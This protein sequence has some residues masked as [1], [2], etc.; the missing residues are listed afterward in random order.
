MQA[1]IDTRSS[2]D[3]MCPA[4][5]SIASLQSDRAACLMSSS[6]VR[7]AIFGRGRTRPKRAGESAHGGPSGPASGWAWRDDKRAHSP[8]L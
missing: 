8:A 7:S 5:R 6:T 2:F 1:S 4:S 3:R